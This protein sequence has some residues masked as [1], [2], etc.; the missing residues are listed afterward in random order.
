MSEVER[1]TT[2]PDEIA[3]LPLL[4]T[5]AYPQTIMPLAI[6]QPES[7]RLIDDLMAGQRIVGLMA[8]KNEDE[9]TN[10]GLPEDF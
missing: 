9:R 1:T 10:P 7:I 8:L 2:I 5:V 6:G 4:G 3:I